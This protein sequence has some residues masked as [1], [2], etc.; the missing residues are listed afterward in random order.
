M[1]NGSFQNNSQI[2]READ[3]QSHFIHF[4]MYQHIEAAKGRRDGEIPYEQRVK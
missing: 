2:L 4:T 3:G 1:S